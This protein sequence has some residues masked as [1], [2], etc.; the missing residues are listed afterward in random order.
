MFIQLLP[1]IP[2]KFSFKTICKKKVENIGSFQGHTK[3]GTAHQLSVI[4]RSFAKFADKSVS[5][6]F[7]ET[8][9]FDRIHG[10]HDAIS[11]ST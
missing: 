1:E 9:Y 4:T 11:N 7:L 8:T 10:I 5:F 3:N 6:P 2:F